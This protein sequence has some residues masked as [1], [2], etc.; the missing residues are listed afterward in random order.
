MRIKFKYNGIVYYPKD[1][2]KKL[3]K[4]GITKDDI[5]VVND[6][7]KIETPLELDNIK[8]YYFTNGVF[9]ITSIYDNLDNLRNMINVDEYVQCYK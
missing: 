6:D 2:N 1:L 7:N 9:T 4:L 3:K 8:K 5:E